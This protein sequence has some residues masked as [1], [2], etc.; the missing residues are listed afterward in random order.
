MW[1]GL[2]ERF[3]DIWRNRTMGRKLELFLYTFLIHFIF[4]KKNNN[5]YLPHTHVG[6]YA[7]CEI[8]S[9][10]HP[11]AYTMYKYVHFSGNSLILIY[12]RIISNTRNNEGI[13]ISIGDERK[14]KSCRAQTQEEI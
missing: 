12:R 13:K 8:A 2:L 11:V 10:T 1:N 5:I 9:A 6:V 3:A 4:V 7:I 14:A